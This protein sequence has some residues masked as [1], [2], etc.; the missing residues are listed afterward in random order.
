[1]IMTY[2]EIYP[3]KKAFIFE[4]DNVLFPEK[5]YDLQVYY[6]FATFLEYQEAFPPANDLVQFMKKVYEKHG[7]ERIF[8][9]AREVYAF[10]RKYE[11]NFK[12][13]Q[14]EA[15]L[16]LKL[17]LY[18]NVLSLLQ[19]MVVDRKSIFIVTSSDP[20]KQLNKI[21]QTEWHG[22]EKFLKVYF[23]DEIEF[24]PGTQVLQL[25]MKEHTLDP[26]DLLMLGSTSTDEIF[27]S[28]ANIDYLAIS[29][30]L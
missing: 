6:L 4:L 14:R 16:P 13:L 18:Q 9:K 8:D 11:E 19:E 22:L 7:P 3:S 28:A 21:R 5:D 25:L 15:K 17:L 26:A 10:D 27:A 24:K 23:A 30:F 29:N 1:M 12:R 20:L 2:D